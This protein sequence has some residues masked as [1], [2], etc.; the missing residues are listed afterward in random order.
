MTYSHLWILENSL[1]NKNINLHPY[2][3]LKNKKEQT[4]NSGNSCLIAIEHKI[5][6]VKH[7]A[8][9]EWLVNSLAT[10]AWWLSIKK[11]HVYQYN[12]NEPV[13]YLMFNWYRMKSE[14]G[15]MAIKRPKIRMQN[16]KIAWWRYLQSLSGIKTCADAQKNLL[17]SDLVLKKLTI[18]LPHDKLSNRYVRTLKDEKKTLAVHIKRFRWL[19]R[20]STSKI[21]KRKTDIYNQSDCHQLK[22]DRW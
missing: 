2:T 10:K 18:Y 3:Q 7:E 19:C 8:V 13:G 12:D 6:M 5:L 4:A 1:Q 22:N 11:T 14:N 16:T 17:G 20:V 9:C 15:K 21:K